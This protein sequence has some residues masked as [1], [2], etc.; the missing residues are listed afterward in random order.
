MN[1]LSEDDV[2]EAIYNNTPLDKIYSPS[3]KDAYNEMAKILDLNEMVDKPV[4]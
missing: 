4:F 1:V 3:V 2:F